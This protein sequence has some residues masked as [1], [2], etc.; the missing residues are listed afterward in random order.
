MS[1]KRILIMAAVDTWSGGMDLMT[2]DT[3]EVYCDVS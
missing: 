3:V 2:I 1:A